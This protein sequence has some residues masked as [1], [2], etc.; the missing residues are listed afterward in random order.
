[1]Y[2]HA[3]RHIQWPMIFAYQ[4]QTDEVLPHTNIKITTEDGC[5]IGFSF[6]CMLYIANIYLWLNCAIYGRHHWSNSLSNY[7]SKYYQSWFDINGTT[8]CD[9]CSGSA[10]CC[11]VIIWNKCRIIH[12][13]ILSNGP[14][15]QILAKFQP[16][17]QKICYENVLENL[18]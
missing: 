7:W 17:R 6:A 13:L 1:M 16:E 15:A 2:T 4:T 9:N 5:Q 14:L 3:I 11:Q 12:I 8:T 18:V 10:V